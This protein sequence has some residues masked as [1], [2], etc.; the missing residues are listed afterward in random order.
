[1]IISP[2]NRS[3]FR[4][5]EI[6]AVLKR[7]ATCERK[8]PPN[9]Q[10]QVEPTGGRIRCSTAA[11]VASLSVLPPP[12]Q[13]AGQYARQQHRPGGRGGRAACR[14]SRLGRHPEGKTLGIGSV[15]D[16]RLDP[17][18][19]LIAETHDFIPSASERVETLAG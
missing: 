5:T 17:S 11:V 3:D 7:R 12:L 14:E 1:M 16:T 10:R 6:V 18:I 13:A 2:Q 8:M 19:A 4:C 9:G 15:D